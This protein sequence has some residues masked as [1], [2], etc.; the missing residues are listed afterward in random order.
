MLGRVGAVLSGTDTAEGELYFDVAGVVVAPERPFEFFVGPPPAIRT[1]K[2]WRADEGTPVL[3]DGIDAPRDCGSAYRFHQKLV[4]ASVDGLLEV[5]QLGIGS[6]YNQRQMP[7]FSFW[8]LANL[9]AEFDAAEMS[10]ATVLQIDEGNIHITQVKL[11][12]CR[13]AVCRFVEMTHSEGRQGSLHEFPHMRVV[14][15]DQRCD[16]S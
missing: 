12:H 9:A 5:T 8:P 2:I 15:E 16:V 6:H 14:I 3:D 10:H 7:N 13:R 1:E 11:C 4:H